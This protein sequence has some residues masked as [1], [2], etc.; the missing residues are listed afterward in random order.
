MKT[1][2]H[3]YDSTVAFALL[4]PAGGPL[5]RS[6]VGRDNPELIGAIRARGVDVH[7]VTNQASLDIAAGTVQTVRPEFG[8]NGLTIAAIGERAL[9]SYGALRNEFPVF[10]PALDA[11]VATINPTALRL[12]GR[13]KNA[14]GQNILL[15]LGLYRQS[16]LHASGALQLSDIHFAPELVAKPNTGFGSRG[17][18]KGTPEELVDAFDESNTEPYLLEERLSFTPHLPVRG[19]DKKEQ[20][21]LDDANERGL[22]KEIRMYSFG[23]GNWH[24]VARIAYRHDLKMSDDEWVFLD[25][26]SVPTVLHDIAS[27]VKSRIDH[28][29]NTTDTLLT[30][31][32]V[33]VA[34]Q[35]NPNPHWEVME[36]N[37]DHY[38]IRPDVDKAT[39]KRFRSLL[40]D[41]IV[42]RALQND[43]S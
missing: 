25:E 3:E 18:G 27:R 20:A 36:I 17:I 15:P 19:R 29:T 11:Q 40:A 10:D 22:N 38:I 14:V 6:L 13:D 21:R 30:V 42:R 5:E 26:D 35:L 9:R 1:T 2:T 12:L 34:S 8:P 41:H 7:V 16:Y 33:Y 28:S 31:D 43:Q 23:D 39:G 32:L 24:S 4:G 37:A